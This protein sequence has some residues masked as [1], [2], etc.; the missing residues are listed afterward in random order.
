MPAWSY[1]SSYDYGTP[2]LGTFH[3]SDL[4]QVFYGILPNYA[5]KSIQNY[6]AN[7][8]YNLNPND[9]GGGTSTASKVA[10]NWPKWADKKQ[11]ANF[12][13]DHASLL[14]DDFR[15]DSYNWIVSNTAVLHI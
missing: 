2:I 11:L 9:A 12:F 6:Y 14:S 13:D 1:L 8:V 5:S 15:S 7:F 10:F 4:L 3:G